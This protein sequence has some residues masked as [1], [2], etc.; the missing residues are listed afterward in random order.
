MSGQS[1]FDNDWLL[2]SRFN[3]RQLDRAM[4]IGT[5]DSE[6]IKITFKE[7]GLAYFDFWKNVLINKL[8][9]ITI[10]FFTLF[11]FCQRNMLKHVKA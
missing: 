9:L 5:S 3:V 1:L 11:K 7:K 8:L 10:G 4:P 2:I 6:V